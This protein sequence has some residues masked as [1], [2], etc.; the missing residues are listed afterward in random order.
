MYTQSE[1]RLGKFSY[2][3]Y[4]DV[5]IVIFLLKITFCKLNS[6]KN[7]GKGTV[8]VHSIPHLQFWRKKKQKKT[9]NL[10]TTDDL[11]ERCR[12]FVTLGTQI[13]HKFCQPKNL[14]RVKAIS[15]SEKILS[16][17]KKYGEEGVCPWIMDIF[18]FSAT[19]N[20]NIIISGA[21]F[22]HYSCNLIERSSF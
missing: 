19:I 1:V 22:S 21:Y 4:Y 15:R 16:K 17:T 18:F 5:M 7:M 2:R 14:T 11:R 20:Y 9:Q 12:W 3:K 6:S 8:K 10:R 13:H